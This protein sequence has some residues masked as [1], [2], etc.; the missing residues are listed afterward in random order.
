MNGDAVIVKD[1]RKMIPVSPD[2]HRRV[3]AYAG[4]LAAEWGARTSMETAI[5]F[6]LD[7]VDGDR[8]AVADEMDT[9]PEAANA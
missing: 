7:I 3:M 5:N 8:P 4:R 1:D 9:Q 2:T 6:A